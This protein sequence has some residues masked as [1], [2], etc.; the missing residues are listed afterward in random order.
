MEVA[1]AIGVVIA[2]AAATATVVETGQLYV[3]AAMKNED[4][5]STGTA[6]RRRSV[7]RTACEIMV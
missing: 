2:A 3:A 1:K 6:V 7:F 4:T 5:T